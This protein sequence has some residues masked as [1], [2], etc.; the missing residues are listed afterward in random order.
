MNTDDQPTKRDIEDTIWVLDR[1]SDW[2]GEQSNALLRDQDDDLIRAII[3]GHTN[4]RRRKIT[5]VVDIL[6]DYK[7][8]QS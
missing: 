2:L 7:N 6:K 4:Y 3:A 8:A 5:S 1:C